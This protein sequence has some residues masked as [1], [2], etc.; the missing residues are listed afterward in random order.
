MWRAWRRIGMGLALGLC[1]LGT[2]ASAQPANGFGAALGI[3]ANYYSVTKPYS[4]AGGSLAGDMQFAVNDA[5]SLN[6]YLML[7]GEAL[8]EGATG[9]ASNGVAGFEVRRWWGERFIGAHLAA[10]STFIATRGSS[11]NLYDP[12]IGITLGVERADGLTYALVADLPRIFLPVA[13]F[14]L[15]HINE[16]QAGLRLHVGYRF[17]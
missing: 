6:P 14:P 9:G 12:G 7:T 11:R 13:A 2:R 8:F 3:A 15:V 1:A 4:S 16:Q 10:Y 17:R 5:W